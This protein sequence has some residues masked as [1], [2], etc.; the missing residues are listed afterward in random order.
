MGRIGRGWRIAV[1]SWALVWETPALLVLPAAALAFGGLAVLSVFLFAGGPAAIAGG[2]VGLG[3]ALWATIL[4]YPWTLVT[5]FCGVAFVSQVSARMDGRAVSVR[6]GL[7]VAWSRR[8]AIAWWALLSAGV[9]AVLRLIGEIPGLGKVGDWIAGLA[10]AAWGLATVFI[11]PVLALE[12][13]GVRRSL[14]TSVK[15]F[16]ARWGEELTGGLVTDVLGGLLAIPGFMA[17]VAG[18]MVFPDSHTIGV[19]LVGIGLVLLAPVLTFM[20]AANDVF[21][22]ALYRHANA[23]TLPEAFNEDQLD[24]AFHPR[25]RRRRRDNGGDG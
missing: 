16:R 3:L 17:L 11:V 6:D 15:T 1:A 5:V 21:L 12:D 24:H 13:A 18:T 2:H 22:V 19:A 25:R 9:A 8:G 23:R 7:R 14:A 20:T 10:G 4:D